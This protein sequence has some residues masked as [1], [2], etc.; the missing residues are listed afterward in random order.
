MLSFEPFLFN[1]KQLVANEMLLQMRRT[2]YV[3]LLRSLFHLQFTNSMVEHVQAVCQYW[4]I[5]Y[6]GFWGQNVGKRAE[7]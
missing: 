5:R 1:L 4:N 2:Q 7:F 3:N 6:A